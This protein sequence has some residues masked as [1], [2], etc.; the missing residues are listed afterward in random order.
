MLFWKFISLLGVM[1]GTCRPNDGFIFFTGSVR[2]TSPPDKHIFAHSLPSDVWLG[3]G[4]A[5]NIT[6]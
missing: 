1:S 3:L 4:H 2:Q 6:P 5:T